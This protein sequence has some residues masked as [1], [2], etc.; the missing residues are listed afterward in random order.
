MSNTAG[1]ANSH[2][3]TVTVGPSVPLPT[4]IDQPGL[5]ETSSGAVAWYGQTGTTHDGVDAA[6]SGGIAN[7]QSSE[8]S[9]VVEGPC[10]ISF[11]WRVSSEGGYDYLR[12]SIDGTEQSGR[13]SG[14]VD[15]Q[16]KTFSI[17]AGSHT[18]KWAYTKDSS[19][20]SGS[21]SGWVDQLEIA[22]I[23][24]PA[25]TTQPQS[26]TVIA[27][28]ETLLTV[29]ANGGLPLNYQW[30][31][32][33]A[34]TATWA[35][36]TEGGSYS[37]VGTAALKIVSITGAMNGDQFRCV[38]SNA[39]GSAT[40]AAA[41]VEVSLPLFPTWSITTDYSASQN[42]IGAWSYGRK[43]SV[44]APAFDLFT[45]R[46]G[47]TGWYLGNYGNGGPS[48]QG[49]PVLWAKANG[50]GYPCVRWTCPKTG[51]YN[52][53]GKFT[54]ADSRGVDNNVYVVIAGTTAMS[55][56][57]QGYEQQAPFQ[58]REVSLTLGQEVDF[59]M[60]WA[61]GVYSE[62][63]WTDLDAVIS[64]VPRIPVVTGQPRSVVN[65]LGRS[66]SVEVESV[67][68]AG[69][70]FQWYRAGQAVVGATTS[71]LR[72]DIVD[73][74][75]A[76]L[77]DVAIT[78][79][80]GS[81]LSR[82]A[83]VGI[84]LPAGERTAGSITTRAGWLDIHHPNGAVYDQFLLTG[85]AATF[86]AGPGKIARC[87]YLDSK[88]SIVQVEM[89]GA[90]AIT[91]VLD[92]PAGPM[93]PALYNQSGIQYMKGDATVILAGAD[94]TTHVSIYSV[95]PL[96]NPGVT[97]AD[98]T[99][100]GWADVR[101]M[102]IVSANG[103]LGGIHQ[104]NVA[105]AAATG[106]AGIYAPTVNTVGSLSVVHA[107]AA[108]GDAIPYLYFGPN[109][110]VVVKIAGSSLAQPNGDSLTV[111]GLIQVQMGAG[112]SSAGTA[113]P[114]QAIQ[115]RLIEDDGTDVTTAIV[116]GP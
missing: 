108:S 92:N 24:A 73:P 43:W 103:K 31:R 72:L 68:P 33:A 63:G 34:G 45:V 10:G 104:G 99:Y 59:T 105:Y 100:A 1:S 79:P 91:I 89:S 20:S 52:I 66:V 111:Q 22:S 112:Q 95:G 106:F 67:G 80:T 60:A 77:Y 86:N 37:N 51:Y 69:S 48:I 7:S 35:D 50:T 16:P 18:L 12:F 54:G 56:R 41:I 114:A 107:I 87:S 85:G 65:I 70:T 83:I 28:A 23:A 46:W 19:T 97:R 49:G 42:P 38:A 44:D 27:G 81:A 75:Q 76:G 55:A 57:L 113:A 9:L 71:T 109:G 3:A 82:P 93:A 110:N 40:S 39:A 58:H 14:T 78:A 94:E 21:D 17:G 4:A 115:T 96:T 8:F 61:G 36:L 32:L 25:I 101:A 5:S 84:M 98:V 26:Q 102:G 116:T 2:T 53:V 15:W 74:N 64:E 90:G 11:W 6:Q 13:I 88:N 62:Y 29:A 30:Q 47:D